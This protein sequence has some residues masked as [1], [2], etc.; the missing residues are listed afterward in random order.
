MIRS[1]LFNELVNLRNDLDRFASHTLGGEQLGTGQARAGSNGSTWAQPM[2]IDVYSTDD[3]AVVI[4]AVPGMMPDDLELSVHQNTVT[5]SGTIN[6]VTDADD[7]RDATWYVSE[8]GSGSYRRSVTLPFP[9]DAEHVSATFEH[10]VVRVTLPKAESAK[11]RKISISTSEKQA[12]AAKNPA[13]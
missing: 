10:G 8:L 6:S 9:I 1:S 5:L 11:P 12:I 2:P 3:H 7:A 4:A 13:A